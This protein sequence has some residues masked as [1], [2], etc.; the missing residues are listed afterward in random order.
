MLAIIGGS[1]LSRL[2]DRVEKRSEAVTTP[3]REEPVSVALFDGPDGELAFL[4]RH[5]LL[6]AVPPHRINYR[7]NVWALREL[8]VTRIFAINIVGGIHEQMGPGA[9]MVPDQIIDYS[10]GRESSF[11]SDDLE[12]VTHIDFTE[13]FDSALREELLAQVE[14]VNGRRDRPHPLQTAGTYGCTQGPRLETAAEIRRLRRDGC[15]IVGMTAMPEAAL[16]REL[17]MRYAMLAYSVN[18][19]AGLSSGQISMEEIRQVLAQGEGLIGEVLGHWL[20]SSEIAR[21]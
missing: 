5:G 11:F 15:D 21:R 4:P 16:A 1:G 6:S 18:W 17:E 12:Q 2:N 7:A 9:F 8:G 3:Y 10:W 20:G 14:T 13:P 19:A